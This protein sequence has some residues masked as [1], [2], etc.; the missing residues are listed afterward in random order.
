MK[1]TVIPLACRADFCFYDLCLPTVRKHS[2][3]L[4]HN[5]IEGSVYSVCIRQVCSI[6]DGC[7]YYKMKI[8]KHDRYN[9]LKQNAKNFNCSYMLMSLLPY[10]QETIWVYINL[11][12]IVICI[13]DKNEI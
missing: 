2:K 5:N 9:V 6:Q 8:F 4:S 11:K 12:K 13:S 1:V 7:H 10:L 3:L